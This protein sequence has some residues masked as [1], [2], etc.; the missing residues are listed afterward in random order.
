[1]YVSQLGVGENNLFEYIRLTYEQAA[2]FTSVHR[3]I[4]SLWRAHTYGGCIGTAFRG[5]RNEG[6]PESDLGGINHRFVL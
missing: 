4:D 5:N 2:L 1:M 3:Y 6:E